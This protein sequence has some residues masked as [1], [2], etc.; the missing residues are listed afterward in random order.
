MPNYTDKEV[1][2]Q[3]SVEVAF[4]VAFVIGVFTVL[5]FWNKYQ[6]EREREAYEEGVR[7]ADRK[8][9]AAGGWGA[10]IAG[11]VKKVEAR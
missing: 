5:Y 2:K 10:W 11:E 1:E 3:N 6:P 4:L 9:E 7:E 8:A